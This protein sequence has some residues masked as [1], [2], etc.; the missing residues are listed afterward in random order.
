MID[1]I[2][3]Y[4]NKHVYTNA[5]HVIVLGTEMKDY[6][7]NNNISKNGDNIHI[8]PNWYDEKLVSEKILITNFS[9]I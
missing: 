4:I 7:L 3:K 1:K 5:S 8:I 6:L 2:M 9:K